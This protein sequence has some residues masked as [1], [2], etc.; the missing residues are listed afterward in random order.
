MRRANS[1]FTAPNTTVDT[2][3]TSRTIA[4]LL[5]PT[6]IALPVAMLLN[7][8]SFPAIAEQFARELPLIFVSGILLFVA[9]LA[10]VRAHNIWSGGWPVLVTVLGWLAIIGGLAR[11]LFPTRAA[12]IAAQFG[13]SRGMLAGTAIVLLLIGAF[14]SFKAYRRD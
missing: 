1:V 10:I 6:L 4:G 5:G 3:T 9:G 12:G 14:L 2:M 13:E 8:G 11:M 7:L